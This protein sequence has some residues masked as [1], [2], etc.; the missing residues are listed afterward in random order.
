MSLITGK[1]QRSLAELRP[2]LCAEYSPNNSKGADENLKVVRIRESTR[3]GTLPYISINN[4]NLL[5]LSYE[6]MQTHLDLS[7]VSSAITQFIGAP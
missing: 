1:V 2:D 3:S 4:D 5:Q 7:L 6:R